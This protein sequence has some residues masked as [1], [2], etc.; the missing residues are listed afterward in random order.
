MLARR[1]FQP[2]VKL[3]AI[4]SQCARLRQV[5]EEQAGIVLGHSGVQKPLDHETFEPRHIRGYPETGRRDDGY[6]IADAD[7]QIGGKAFAQDDGRQIYFAFG[8][9]GPDA[10][11]M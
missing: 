4:R 7:I 11:R 2:T 10:N 9:K 5:N 8:A 1:T 6:R 3:R